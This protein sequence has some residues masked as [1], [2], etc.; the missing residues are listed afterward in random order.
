MQQYIYIYFTWV[1]RT[2]ASFDSPYA[3]VESHLRTFHEVSLRSIGPVAAW[4]D[5]ATV[6]M[7]ASSLDAQRW[8]RSLLASSWCD[9]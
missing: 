8:G 9:T 2:L 3:T 1:N 5:E 6:T 4:A 7:R